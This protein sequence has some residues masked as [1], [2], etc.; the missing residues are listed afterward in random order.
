MLG[1][2]CKNS[3][4]KIASSV[5]PLSFT[6][7]KRCLIYPATEHSPHNPSTFYIWTGL[8]IKLQSLAD[9][10]V[11][12]CMYQCWQ[13]QT[14]FGEEELKAQFTL[15]DSCLTQK[16]KPFFFFLIVN[17]S[18]FPP[19][20]PLINKCKRKPSFGFID[21]FSL[22]WSSFVE[23]NKKKGKQQASFAVSRKTRTAGLG[24]NQPLHPPLMLHS[25]SCRL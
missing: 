5:F 23:R 4:L 2:L 13:K 22:A 12:S 7:S 18:L 11:H 10:W 8:K 17:A 6:Q 9:A 1:L 15:Q 21:A 19:P 20:A 24:I 14:N 25:G 3:Q 16:G